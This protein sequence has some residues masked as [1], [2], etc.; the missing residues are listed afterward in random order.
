MRLFLGIDRKARERA[1]SQEEEI[2]E[3]PPKLT[4][5]QI[6]EKC[7]CCGKTGH[8]DDTCYSRNKP[9]HL[10]FC[11]T[12]SEAKQFYQAAA[13]AA[14]SASQGGNNNASIAPSQAPPQEEDD[15]ESVTSLWQG[16][17]PGN[18]SPSHAEQ[19]NKT[20]AGKCQAQNSQLH[21]K[22]H[23]RWHKPWVPLQ[24]SQQGAPR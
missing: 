2:K 10:W 23:Q 11:N 6:A 8:K 24:Q 18:V 15:A 16:G 20:R 4:F 1:R 19:S 5:A 9:K 22:L 3:E 21:S 12:N 7:K 17:F 14:S 13:D